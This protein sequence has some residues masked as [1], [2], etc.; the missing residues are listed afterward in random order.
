VSLIQREPDRCV[1]ERGVKFSLS[2]LTFFIAG[3]D[4]NIRSDERSDHYCEWFEKC[5]E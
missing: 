1:S 2:G 3:D 4:P 5:D